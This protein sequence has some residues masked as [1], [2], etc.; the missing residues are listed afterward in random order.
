MNKGFTFSKS[1]YITLLSLKT[2]KLRLELA[3][4]IIEYG[5]LGKVKSEICLEISELMEE[6]KPIIRETSHW[7]NRY[8]T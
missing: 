5:I 8:E 2:D 6:I 1:F 4:A 3:N 7:S